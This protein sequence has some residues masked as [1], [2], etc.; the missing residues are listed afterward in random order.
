MCLHAR[1]RNHRRCRHHF[2]VAR[3]GGAVVAGVIHPLRHSCG[4]RVRRVARNRQLN[5][6][7]CRGEAVNSRASIATL[8]DCEIGKAGREL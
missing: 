1:S 5:G 2:L 8:Q 7:G 6:R 4:H 3:A